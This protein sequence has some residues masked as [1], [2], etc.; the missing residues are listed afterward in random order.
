MVKGEYATLGFIS[1]LERP[2]ATENS[3]LVDQLVEAGAVLYVKTNVPQTLFVSAH[4]CSR[5][6]PPPNDTVLI[7]RNF[8]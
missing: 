7:E 2:A 6:L 1:Y 4:H 5:C 8:W 3:V